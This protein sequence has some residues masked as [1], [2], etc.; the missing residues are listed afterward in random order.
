MVN[1]ENIPEKA[2]NL[3]AYWNSKELNSDYAYLYSNKSL[4]LLFTY[5]SSTLVKLQA[6]I[7]LVENDTH[8]DVLACMNLY[9]N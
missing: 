7:Y 2:I 8:L 6:L 1:L 5:F 3:M 4:I 9:S